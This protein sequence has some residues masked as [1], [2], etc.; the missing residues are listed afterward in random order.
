MT[1]SL[2]QNIF[3][4]NLAFFDEQVWACHDYPSDGVVTFTNIVAEC[5]G[6][7]CTKDIE[8]EARVKDPNCEM[9]AHVRKRCKCFVLCFPIIFSPL[10][11][12]YV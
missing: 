7:E 11:Q 3:S 5:D 2:I 9:T 6:K 1:S 10:I 12:R 4:F 8:W